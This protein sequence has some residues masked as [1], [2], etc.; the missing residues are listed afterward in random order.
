MAS[1]ILFRP[2]LRK[3]ARPARLALIACTFLGMAKKEPEF[4]VRF[5]AEA[6]KEDTDRFAKPLTF[7]HPKREGY[8]ENIPT[9]HEKNVKAV[10]PLQAPDGTWGCT[11]LLDNRGRIALEVLSTQRRG[12]TLVAFVG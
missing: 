12:S 5:Y 4:T 9:I 3:I 8:V 7:R 11:F 6:K 1:L 2:T 10:Y